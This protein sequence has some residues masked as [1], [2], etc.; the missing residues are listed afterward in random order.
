MAKIKDPGFGYASNKKAARLVNNDG[1]FNIKHINKRF[2]VSE[3]YSHLIQ[4]SWTKFFLY[5]VA[6]Y[7]LV[8]LL[9]ATIYYS[10]GVDQLSVGVKDDLQDFMNAFFFSTQTLTTLG[11][12]TISPIGNLS[13][14]VSSFEALIG[15]LSFS[16]MTGLLY[17]R[18]SRPKAAI[19]FSETLV[20][21][22]FKEHRAIMFR[23]MNKRKNIMIEP[24]INITLAINELNEDGEFKRLFF[25]LE[26]ER[27]RIMY[28]P[29]TWTIVHEIDEKSPLFKYSD[30]E[31]EKLNAELFILIQYY[32]DAFTQNVYQIHSY[33]FS[34][35]K[36]GEKFI[37]AYYFD[38][39]G[40]TVLDHTK[41]SETEY[42][43][44]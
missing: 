44:A 39:E 43:K 17:G 30:E 34:N 8:N 33:D 24:E 40:R 41:L 31:I 10:I 3:V 2:A 15:L 26:L 19:R 42:F 37:P 29:T 16:L 28:L 7:I 32:E 35:M 11:Y 12:G 22:S 13:G 27:H 20:L 14:L 21:R 6:G 38:T 5:V 9:F 18:F 23:L 36:I 4:I 1:S 25:K